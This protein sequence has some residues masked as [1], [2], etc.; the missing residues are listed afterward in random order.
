M[1]EC[2]MCGE[3]TDSETLL[4]DLCRADLRASV[5][6]EMPQRKSVTRDTLLVDGT[7]SEPLP[8]GET[9]LATMSNAEGLWRMVIP[10]SV[11]QQLAIVADAQFRCLT[12][13]RMDHCCCP[14]CSTCM[15]GILMKRKAD[16]R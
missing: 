12:C 5:D 6:D 13:G 4:C 8:P 11:A 7:P 14:D 2:R 15:G 1:V 9:L 10:G 3:Q 16:R